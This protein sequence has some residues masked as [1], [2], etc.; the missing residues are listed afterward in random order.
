MIFSLNA[1]SLVDKKTPRMDKL[2]KFKSFT[3]KRGKMESYCFRRVFKSITCQSTVESAAVS[4][5]N[6]SFSL[7]LDIR[8]NEKKRGGGKWKKNTQKSH[9]PS[10]TP[11]F[12]LL[13]HEIIKGNKFFMFMYFVLLRPN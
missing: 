13:V 11:I 6:I 7:T 10:P 1:L 8:E 5:V 4:L 12:V 3:L 9:A 2:S